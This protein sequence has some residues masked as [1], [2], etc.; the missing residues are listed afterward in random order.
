MSDP[1][2]IFRI[3]CFDGQQVTSDWLKAASDEE[4]IAQAHAR[5]FGAKCEIWAGER[6]VAQLE[7][8]RRQA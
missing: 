7:G 6:L 8:Q 3:Y 4:A 5:G 2:K 1:L